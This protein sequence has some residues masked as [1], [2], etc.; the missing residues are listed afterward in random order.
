MF[1]VSLSGVAVERPG[2]MAVRVAGSGGIM[3]ST[4]LNNGSSRLLGGICRDTGSVPEVTTP[5]RSFAQPTNGEFQEPVL[6]SVDRQLGRWEDAVE[7]E[8]VLAKVGG[9]DAME[10]EQG[11]HVNANPIDVA[12]MDKGAQFPVKT[13]T[14]SPGRTSSVGVN[15]RVQVVF[16]D[17]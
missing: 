2:V 9:V 10:E 12:V 13:A 17:V 15:D 3:A 14:S 7:E 1:L 16:L 4:T 5:R 8:E 11:A 6:S